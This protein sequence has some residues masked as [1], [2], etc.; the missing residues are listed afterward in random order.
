MSKRDYYEVLGVAK[1]AGEADLKKAYRKLAMKHHPDRNPGDAK[2]EELFKEASEA[3]EVLTDPRRREIYDRY[4]HDGLKGAGGGGG[5]DFGGGFSDLFGDVFADI[6]GGRSG[7]RRG[8]D[9][10]YTMELSLEDAVRGVEQTVRIPKRKACESCNGHGTRDGQKPASCPTCHGAGQ[11]RIQQGF[12]TLQQTC[13][14]CSG[15]GTAV[16]D[17]CGDCRGAGQVRYDKTL[18]VRI[19]AGVDTG[20]RIRLNGEGEPGEPGAPAGDLY[21]QIVVKP[22]DFFVRDGDD[23][24]CE[25]PV[26]FV[27]AALGGELSVPTLDGEATLKIPEGTQSG[28]VFRLRGKGVRSVRGAGTGDLLCRIAIETP[29]K[30]SSR[31]KE[32][33]RE[34]GE[35]L[36]KQGEKHNPESTSWVEK[37]K[38]FLEEHLG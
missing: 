13:P 38:R 28:K 7:P 31:Q 11:V 2:S 33:L 21:V 26:S 8:A 30:L 34:F 25:V 10:R 27:S 17:P 14:Q 29:V 4:G 12:F 6:F 23:L 24:H 37:A 18:S 20:D 19:P 22:H 36:D 16:S 9:L 5:G 15:R 32:L 1:G 3:Y 35:S